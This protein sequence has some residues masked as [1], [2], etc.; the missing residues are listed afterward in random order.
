M[1][2][3][4]TATCIECGVPSERRLPERFPHICTRCLF[5]SQADASALLFDLYAKVKMPPLKTTP[6]PSRWSDAS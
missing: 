1:S 4:G 6:P 3:H 5:P 2:D